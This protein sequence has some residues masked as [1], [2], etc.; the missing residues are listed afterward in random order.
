MLHIPV[1]LEVKQLYIGVKKFK[2]S[3]GINH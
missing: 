3:V 1:H 2:P